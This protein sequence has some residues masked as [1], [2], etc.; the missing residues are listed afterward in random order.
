M[1]LLLVIVAALPL[2]AGLAAAEPAG[3]SPAATGPS[4]QEVREGFKSLFDG[5]SL[6][7]WQG[8]L[9]GYVPRAGVLVCQ[10]KGGGKLFTKRQYANFILRFEFNL[11]PGGNNGVAI[12]APMEGR[13]SRAG[14]EI[15]I[16]DDSADRYKHLKPYQYHGSIYGMV[17]AKRGQLRPPGQWNEE[18][19]LCD[20]PHVKVTLNGAVIVDADLTK[21]PDPP[22]DGNDHPGRRRKTGFVGFIGHGSRVQFRNIRLKELP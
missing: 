12:R 7:G 1:R 11:E 13:P 8:S 2:G 20:G 16:L 10:K 17:P 4:R 9:K 3:Q 14:M 6:E 22:M 15:Q 5:R 18:E 19:I 21:I